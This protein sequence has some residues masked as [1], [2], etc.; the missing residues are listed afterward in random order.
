VQPPDIDKLEN[1][2]AERGKPLLSTAKLLTGS[3]DAAEDLLQAALE[4]LLKHWSK[5]DGDP[6]GY[7]RRTLYNL[8]ADGWRRRRTSI[9]GLRRLR[10]GAASGP[11]ETELV[12]LRDALVRLMLKLPPRQRAVIVLR[13]WEGLTGAEVAGQLGCPVG[14]VK[15]AA[16]RGARP[17]R[18]DGSLRPR[19]GGARRGRPAEL[20][21]VHP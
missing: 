17:A 4:R 3:Q 1:F 18:T 13:Y 10:G 20:H 16:S 7:L 14:N 12:D 15:S 8:A 11:A 19:R 6:E 21:R 9:A 2:L 5:I